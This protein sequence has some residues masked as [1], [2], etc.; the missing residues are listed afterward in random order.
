M[1]IL[2]VYFAPTGLVGKL[3]ARDDASA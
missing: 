2:V 3:G 1:F